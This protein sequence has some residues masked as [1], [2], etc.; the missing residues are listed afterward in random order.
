MGHDVYSG[1]TI[2]NNHVHFYC[3][4]NNKKYRFQMSLPKGISFCL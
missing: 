3:G 4:Q 2:T 1:I